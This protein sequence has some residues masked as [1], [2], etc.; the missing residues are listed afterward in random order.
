M[1]KTPAGKTSPRIEGAGFFAKLK[2]IVNC[3][4][5]RAD[6]VVPSNGSLAKARFP[7]ATI[8]PSGGGTSP[9][10]V[11]FDRLSKPRLFLTRGT[12]YCFVPLLPEKLTSFWIRV[13]LEERYF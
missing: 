7:V 3:Q 12:D 2:P 10:L 1:L 5:K 9:G 11:F 6:I 4:E 13:S 8:R